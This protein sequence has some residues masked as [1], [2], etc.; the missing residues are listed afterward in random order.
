MWKPIGI[1]DKELVNSSLRK[2]RYEISE[3]TFTNLFLWQEGQSI[4]YRMVNGY[5]VIKS[6]DS[7][8]RENLLM[9]V[10][11]GG[12]ADTLREVHRLMGK[13]GYYFRALTQEMCEEIERA[14]PGKFQYSPT[15]E[16]S[17]YV[18]SAADLIALPGNKYRKKRNFVTGFERDYPYA[19][20]K[21]T[22]ALDYKVIESQVEW[23]NQN[24]CDFYPELKM[25]AEGIRKVL[26]HF[27]QLD[28]SGG[29]IEVE[30]KVVAYTFGEQLNDETVVIHIEKANNDY[31]GAY[32]MINN[33][34]LREEW[35]QM[36]FVNREGDLGIPGLRRAKESYYPEHMID[37][38]MA[39]PF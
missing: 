1:E 4:T 18:Y 10:G 25:E 32:Q 29:L 23:C 38:F 26:R 6:I 5:L 39:V 2:K 9:P 11:T 24:N 17:D 37:K 14:W 21:L 16:V 31:R 15:P 28:F 20:R 34:Y 27:C 35:S 7:K 8:G 22:K 36:T 13:G 3:L 33:L 30:G 19:Y 12:L